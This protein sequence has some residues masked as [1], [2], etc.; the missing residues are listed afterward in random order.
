M[1]VMESTVGPKKITTTGLA[2]LSLGKGSSCPMYPGK[3]SYALLSPL[4]NGS[5]AR[6]FPIWTRGRSCLTG[7]I[8][9]CLGR[10]RRSRSKIVD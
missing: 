7:G 4:E 6:P 2:L 3:G 8:C 9:V 1:A 10:R 5:N